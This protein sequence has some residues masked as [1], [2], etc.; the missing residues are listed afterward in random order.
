M[1]SDETC[2]PYSLCDSMKTCLFTCPNVTSAAN[3]STQV[4][5]DNG[6]TYG[7]MDQMKSASCA[8]KQRITMNHDG[9]CVGML[10]FSFENLKSK[11]VN[12][13]VIIFGDY[14]VH[15]CTH[16]EVFKPRNKTHNLMPFFILVHK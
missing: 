10:L 9:P 3:S 2:P 13:I 8:M 11:T 4:C 16:A 15:I 7:N 12:C 6:K 1:C 14:Q 5:G